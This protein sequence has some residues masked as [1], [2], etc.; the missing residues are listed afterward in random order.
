MICGRS[1]GQRLQEATG[2]ADHLRVRLAIVV[3]GVLFVV[4]EMVGQYLGSVDWSRITPLDI[5]AAL[6]DTL[7]AVVVAM[8]VLVAYD[9]GRRRWVPAF[10]AW[11]RRHLRSAASRR[12]PIGVPSWRTGPGT[13]EVPG[14]GPRTR[15]A[16]APPRA[17]DAPAVRAAPDP[18]YGTRTVGQRFPEGPGRL[19]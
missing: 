16:M 1:S 8:A 10:R 4:L 19:L 17:D 12:E 7:L 3:Y 5:A 18:D 11:Q 9:V 2:G 15:T 14:A 6:V 13:R